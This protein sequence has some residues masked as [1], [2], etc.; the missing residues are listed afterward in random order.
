AGNPG[1]RIQK[2]DANGNFLASFGSHG[3]GNGEFN[4]I[5]HLGFDHHDHLFAT[6]SGNNRVV[7]MDS[8]TGAFLATYD[9]SGSSD[10]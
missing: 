3:S 1:D 6:D 4:C 7:E 10:S 8:D 9:L 2:F 5:G